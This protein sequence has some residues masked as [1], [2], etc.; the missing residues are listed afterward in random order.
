VEP[1]A[2]HRPGFLAS[3]GWPGLE[4]VAQGLPHFG[5]EVAIPTLEL[6]KVLAI[7][8]GLLGDVGQRH[9]DGGY[10]VLEVL[11]AED[12]VDGA[13]A[14][15]VLWGGAEL[16]SHFREPLQSAQHMRSTQRI[17][18]RKKLVNYIKRRVCAVCII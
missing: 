9:V 15:G 7:D 12:G 17:D 6:G 4:K 1:D 13:V 3:G 11:F 14:R 16:D 8:A 10:R 2:P 18:K 5:A